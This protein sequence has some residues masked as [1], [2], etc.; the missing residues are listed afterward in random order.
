MVPATS[1]L[2]ENL[3]PSE[4]TVSSS[5]TT[6]DLETIPRFG[7]GKRK[8]QRTRTSFVTGQIS[9]LEREF[10]KSHYP[11]VYT[12]ER[13]ASMIGVPEARVQVWFSNRRA[14]W[15]RQEKIRNSQEGNCNGELQQH[16]KDLRTT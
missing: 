1:H 7:S 4:D 10:E 16:Q 14:K 5:T 8:F 6:G 2:N 3:H 12:R 13:L 11:D 9:I 15:R